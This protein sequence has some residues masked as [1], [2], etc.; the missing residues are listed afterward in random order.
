MSS[1]L[2]RADMRTEVPEQLSQCRQARYLD[3]I[4]V[5]QDHPV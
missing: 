4:G 1:G 3:K 5:A 2:A